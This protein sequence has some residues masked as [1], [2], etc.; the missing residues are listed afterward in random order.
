MHGNKDD[1]SAS[2]WANADTPTEQDGAAE[3]WLAKLMRMR[4][5]VYA[6]EVDAAKLQPVFDYTVKAGAEDWTVQV[7]KLEGETTEYYAKSDYTRA[8]VNLTESLASEAIAD[9]DSLLPPLE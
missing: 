9:L 2:F 4:V 5:Q 6:G 1:R 8:L 7:F 3:A